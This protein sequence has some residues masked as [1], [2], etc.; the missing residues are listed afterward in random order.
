MP[1]RSIWIVITL[2]GGSVCAPAQWL[3]YPTA[4]TPRT[5][6]G[7]PILSAPTPR[8]DGKPDLSGVWE[9]DRSPQNEIEYLLPEK[10]NGL[11]EDFPTK[12][13]LDILSDFKPENTPL[14]PSVAAALMLSR[15]T[16]RKDNPGVHCLPRGSSP[17]G[18]TIP[19]P[20]K[21]V[22]TPGLIVVLIEDGTNFRQIYTDG[23]KLPEDPTP[24][25]FGYSV[26]KW[27]GDTLV[28][29]TIGFNDRGWLDAVG[30]TR[31]EAMHVSERFHRRD[32]GHMDMQVTL[33]DPKTFTKPVTVKFSL[34]LQPDGDVLELFCS[35]DEKDLVHSV[36]K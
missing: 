12:Y 25:W 15:T 33:D 4:G 26:G 31:S 18:D 23:R 36:N 14:L 7:K 13:F 34:S 8:R 22:Q 2:L 5:K 29:D 24:S 9:A 35:E 3:N 28:V 21:L 16:V 17:M 6:D 27:E 10:Q 30:H 32:F 19:E 20:F 1:T 11:G